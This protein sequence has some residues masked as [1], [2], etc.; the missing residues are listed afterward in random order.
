M[1]PSFI[2]RNSWQLVERQAEQLRKTCDGNGT[3]TA[4]AKLHLALVD[5]AVDEVAD[6]PGAVLE[7]G[8][9][10][11][12]KIGSRSLRNFLWSGGSICSGISGRICP[13]ATA[14]IP[15][16]K[17]SGCWRTWRTSASP[18]TMTMSMSPSAMSTHGPA[19]R[20]SLYMGWGWA[21]ASRST[22]ALDKLTSDT[23]FPLSCPGLPGPRAPFLAEI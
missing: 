16:L 5:E 13:M 7:Q 1:M 23:C 3:R 10:L 2:L 14:S 4:V 8:H 9:C 17:I 18:P 21:S 6:Q 11:G 15:E 22:S 20:S 19:S 12:A